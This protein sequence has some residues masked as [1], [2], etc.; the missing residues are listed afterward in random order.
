MNRALHQAP[1]RQG[2]RAWLEFWDNR[3]PQVSLFGKVPVE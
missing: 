3:V 2:E 1:R